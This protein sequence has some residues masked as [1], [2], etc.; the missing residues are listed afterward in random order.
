MP[1]NE[2]L[3]SKHGLMSKKRYTIITKNEEKS[4]VFRFLFFIFATE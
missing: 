1:D 2:C 4:S 3:Y